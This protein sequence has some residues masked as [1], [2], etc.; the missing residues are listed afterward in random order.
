LGNS[1]SKLMSE[2]NLP[3]EQ[4]D[5]EIAE[6][7][8]LDTQR[9]NNKI[10]LIASENYASKAV[11][12]ATGS[13]LTNKY[14][15]GYPGKR[16][17]GG[18]ENADIVERIAIE[19]AKELFGAEHANAQPHAGSQANMAAYFAFLKPGDTILAMEL[20]HG[21][22]LTHGSPVNFSGTLYKSCAYG[23]DPETELLDY[24]EIQRLANECQPK[25]IMT[26]ATVYPRYIDFAQFRKIAD[27]VGAVL[28]ADIAHTAGLVAA[29][30]HPSPVPY[31]DAVTFTTHKT[32]RGPRSGMILCKEAHAKAI[33][34]AVFPGLQGGPLVHV[35]AA[36]A[37]CLKEAMQPS[38][39]DYQKQVK[40]NARA[41]A[42]ELGKRGLRLVSGGTDTHLMLAD[43]TPLNITGKAAQEALDAVGIVANKNMIPFDKQK[44]MVTSGIRIGTPCVTTRGMKEPEMAKIADLIIRCITNLGDSG[45][46]IA[47]RE[48]VAREVETL[49]GEFPVYNS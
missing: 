8:R 23:V 6:A 9:Q 16:Y 7:I 4:V 38:F 30:E 13:V 10:L 49:A 28:I 37:V 17:Y 24:D 31:C 2:L 22:H 11:M 18:C 36:K 14:A 32:L 19:R 46:E 40:S 44:P 48:S 33:D 39:K 26:G 20:A 27:S 34:R 47:A 12:Q 35:V 42:D 29:G 41:L 21:G 3:L 5:P 43:L 45:A 15:E 1:E 25:A